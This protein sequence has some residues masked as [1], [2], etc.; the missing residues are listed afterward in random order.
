MYLG[1]SY[2]KLDHLPEA[3]AHVAQACQMKTPYPE[4][5]NNLAFIQI[6]ARKPA[7]ANSVRKVP[8]RMRTSCRRLQV[9]T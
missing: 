8:A 4:C 2:L 3:E 9:L 7:Q 5:W 1:M 6:Q